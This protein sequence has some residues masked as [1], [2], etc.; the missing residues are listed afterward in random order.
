LTNAI[1]F[2]ATTKT[3]LLEV[4]VAVEGLSDH[5][6]AAAIVAGGKKELGKTDIAPAENLEALIARGIR[7]T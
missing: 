5:P 4:A 2:G 1:P 7:A 3:H 6:L